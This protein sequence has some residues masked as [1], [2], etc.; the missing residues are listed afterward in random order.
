LLLWLRRAVEICRKKQRRISPA[1]GAHA[2]PGRSKGAVEKERVLLVL[3]VA[4]IAQVGRYCES[5]S[6][7]QLLRCEHKV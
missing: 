3:F 5:R 6:L 4:C 7:F 2:A 1:E